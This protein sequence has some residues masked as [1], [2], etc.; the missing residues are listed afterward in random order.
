MDLNSAFFN[1]CLDYVFTEK[2]PS[3]HLLDLEKKLYGVETFIRLKQ[4][5]NKH[6]MIRLMDS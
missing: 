3:F 6:V 4:K 1:V 2:T 5:K